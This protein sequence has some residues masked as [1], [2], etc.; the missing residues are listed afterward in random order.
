MRKTTKPINRYNSFKQVG[1][2]VGQIAEQIVLAQVTKPRSTYQLRF[3]RLSLLIF[4]RCVPQQRQKMSGFIPIRE[5][6]R[7]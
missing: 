3:F 5:I 2:I 6:L 1:Q 7:Q 4:V